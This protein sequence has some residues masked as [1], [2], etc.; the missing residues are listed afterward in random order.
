M[1]N[2]PPLSPSRELYS[3]IKY[4]LPPSPS[5]WRRALSL[6]AVP[7]IH[8]TTSAFGSRRDK[9]KEKRRQSLFLNGPGTSNHDGNLTDGEDVRIRK[10][11]NTPIPGPPETVDPFPE[12]HSI[13]YD[14]STPQLQHKPTRSMSLPVSSGET[15]L[16]MINHY[17]NSSITSLDQ[18]VD[19]SVPHAEFFSAYDETPTGIS[20]SQS[21]SRLGS[22]SELESHSPSTNSIPSVVQESHTDQQQVHE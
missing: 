11:T 10:P 1:N 4:P 6:V 17:P 3:P 12:D 18:S 13:S 15:D 7:S 9:D 20:Q 14:R 8:R 22:G 2:D 19:T 5:P 16:S 21:Q